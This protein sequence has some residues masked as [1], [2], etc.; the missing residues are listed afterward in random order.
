MR[1]RIIDTTKCTYCDAQT[2]ASKGGVIGCLTEKKEPEPRANKAA[3]LPPAPAEG[4]FRSIRCASETVCLRG[5][6]KW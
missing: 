5:Q 1:A 4:L 3:V 2:R 6:Q